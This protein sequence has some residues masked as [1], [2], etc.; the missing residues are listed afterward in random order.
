MLLTTSFGKNFI[1][2]IIGQIVTLFGS[3]LLRFVLSLYVLD[4]TGRADVFAALY[5]LSAIPILLTP[6][7]GAIADRVNR[8]KMMVAIDFTNGLIVL[9]FI[10]LT[11]NGKPSVFAIGA[12]MVLLGITSAMES[13]TVQACV[14]QTVPEEKLEQANGIIQGTGSL[15]Q[16]IAPVL[17]GILYGI[18]SLRG[19]IV[20]SC[21][22][23]FLASFMEVFIRILFV[24]RVQ[25][26]HIV[27]TIIADLKEGFAYTVQQ[28]LIRSC[29]ILAAALN[30][31]LAPYFIV[32][33]PIVLRMTMKSTG[34]LYGTGMAI[35]EAGM[36]LGA[37]A[38]GLFAKKMRMRTLHRWIAGAAFLLTGTA[39]SL[40][41]QVLAL[42]YYPA[43][44]VFFLFVLPAVMAITM[45]S[46]Y[47]ITHVQKNTPDALLGKVMAIITAAAQCAAP[48]GQIVC[49]FL[50]KKFSAA[51]YIPTIALGMVTLLIAAAGKIMLRNGEK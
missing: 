22:A 49:G 34:A 46:I 11:A 45:I 6:V 10:L 33:I 37:L 51:V 27:P 28:P 30:L 1:L 43:F 20:C 50:F 26:K 35:I 47:V 2:L 12:V 24:K 40:L 15:A 16:I 38:V 31:V 48:A 39:V 25:E 7:G 8:C 36:I 32:G 19:L 17:G 3:A 4:I 18:F 5:A 13:P 9:G 42:G 14:P 29:M 23:F 41:P 21:A 44:A